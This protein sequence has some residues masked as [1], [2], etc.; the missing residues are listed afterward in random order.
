MYIYVNRM[1]DNMFGEQLQKERERRSWSIRELARR[2]GVSP[3]T[4]LKVERGRD[5]SVSI[6]KSL[7]N[8]L[9]V[10][11]D[12]LAGTFEPDDNLKAPHAV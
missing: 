8:A 5:P 2:A 6:A 11:I 3:G 7:A 9:S 10:S 1:E 12:Y 4:V